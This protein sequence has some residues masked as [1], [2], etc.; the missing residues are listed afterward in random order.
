MGSKRGRHSRR[1]VIVVSRAAVPLV[2]IF[3]VAGPENSPAATARKPSSFNSYDQPVP[4][5][6]FSAR[7]RTIGSMNRAAILW[8]CIQE[9]VC[10][11]PR[12]FASLGGSIR[13]RHCQTVRRTGY[14]IDPG[15]YTI[16]C[17][18]KNHGGRSSGGGRYCAGN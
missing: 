11:N 6:S 17:G 14:R 5:G 15:V 12:A 1:A 7:S 18:G 9:P 8:S 16:D 3:V 2:E 13:D 4:C 10:S